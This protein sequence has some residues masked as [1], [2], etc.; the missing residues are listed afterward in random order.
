MFSELVNHVE[1]T[2]DHVLHGN[3]TLG[4]KIECGAE[5][6]VGLLA[7]AALGKFVGLT[8]LAGAESSLPKLTLTE[9]EAPLLS[10]EATLSLYKNLAARDGEFTFVKKPY[11]AMIR[12]GVPGE[13]V[14]DIQGKPQLV[15]AGKKVVSR[16][17]PDGKIDTY[18]IPH[19]IFLDRWQP[20]GKLADEYM[21]RPVP[22]K[23]VLLDRAVQIPGHSGPTLGSVEDMIATDGTKFWTLQKE[24]LR[25]TYLPTDQRSQHLLAAL[26]TQAFWKSHEG[27]D[28]SLLPELR[29]ASS[30]MRSNPAYREFVERTWP[31]QK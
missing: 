29:N 25:Q 10:D 5:A 2:W 7:V 8:R 23:M 18:P 30:A 3:S 26:D 28:K 24:P 6:S 4:E 19:Q 27:I 11:T 9:G 13:T 21:P 15:E 17:M 16:T 12:D 1:Q 31:V 22:T 20:S 14:I